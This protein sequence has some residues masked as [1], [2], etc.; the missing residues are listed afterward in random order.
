VFQFE[1]S[2]I[3]DLLRKLKPD[4]F[5]DLIAC[6]ALYRP[7]PLQG[8]MVDDFIMRKHGKAEISY[9]HALL[10]PVLKD[11]YG[12]M[13]Y[14]EQV[15]QI[16]NHLG[17][18]SMSDAYTL[19]KAISKKKADVIEARREAFV[20]GAIGKG[21]KKDI[22]ESIFDLITYFGGYGFNKSHSTAYALISY[23]TAY[24]KANWPVEFYAAMFTFE[25][26]NTD[27]LVEFIKDAERFG[28]KIL[29]PDANESFADFRPAKTQRG[30]W[31]IRYGLAALKGV[32]EKAVEAIVQG[33]EKAGP[34]RSIFHLAES[35][36]VH[37]VNKSVFEALVKSGAL[38][39]SGAKR[40][41]MAAVVAD[42]L[43]AGASAQADQKSGQTTF[44]SAISDFDKAAD[45]ASLPE[46][47]EWSDSERSV[48][49]KEALGFYFSSNPLTEFADVVRRYASSEI[50][51]LKA[52]RDT[53]EIVIGGIVSIVK[54]TTVK[55]GRNKN[56]RM[57]TFTIT[58]LSGASAQAVIFPNEYRAHKDLIV[59][60]SVVML[61]GRLDLSR[62]LPNVKV[63][64]VISMKDA[65]EKLAKRVLLAISGAGLSDDLLKSIA[66]L[67]AKHPGKLPVFFRVESGGASVIVSAGAQFCV[68]PT[69]E[70]VAKAEKLVGQGRVILS[71]GQRARP[72]AAVP[73]ESPAE[74]E[75]EEQ[76]AEA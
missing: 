16:L 37:Q 68:A 59:D 48:G 61:R 2:G 6:V 40:S 46:I 74:Y 5:S 44:F 8:G 63:S 13:A 56:E 32:G 75:T 65:D 39:F 42:V 3:R 30:K 45:S 11:T 50:A 36:D 66:S 53:S 12:V 17:G 55:N 60:E 7:G 9:K 10:E 21:V 62:D 25:M 14:Q 51:G 47:E 54:P 29:P 43:D 58:D 33:R 72:A 15:I 24:L 19:I 35:V 64:D 1:S 34:F 41:Q 4:K 20:N 28:I 26:G 18:M 31:A 49:E 69:A 27:K 70:F 71:N 23:Q 22:A 52:L 67:I 38:D 57:A 76:F 73:A